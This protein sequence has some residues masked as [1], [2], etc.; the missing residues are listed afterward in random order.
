[1]YV[2]TYEIQGVFKKYRN[3]ISVYRDRNENL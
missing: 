3:R 1:M 2:L